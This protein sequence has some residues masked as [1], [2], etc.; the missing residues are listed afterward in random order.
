MNRINF[1]FDFAVDK[2]IKEEFLKYIFEERGDKIA[3][4]YYTILRKTINNAEK[5][6]NCLWAK[7]DSNMVD[8]ALMTVNTSSIATITT[9]IS[10]IRDYLLSTT[11]KDIECKTGYD[12]TF[13]LTIDDMRR[14]INNDTKTRRY[15]TPKEL[16]EIVLGDNGE[17]LSRA[18]CVLLYSG[19][20][21]EDILALTIDGINYETGDIWVNDK[22]VGKIDCKYFH[23]I[24]EAVSKNTFSHFNKVKRMYI[25]SEFNSY[26]EHEKLH[27]PKYFLRRF[28]DFQKENWKKPSDTIILSN[29]IN[30]LCYEIGY[31]IDPQS[32]QMSRVMYDLLQ[33]CNFNIPKNF[34]L[35][36]FKKI[37]G[38]KTTLTTAKDIC[39]LL[40]SKLEEDDMLNDLRENDRFITDLN[41]NEDIINEKGFLEGKIKLKEHRQKERNQNL[42]K[43]AKQNFKN[44]NGKIFCEICGF[45]FEKTY[46]ER[47]KDFIEVHHNI[48]IS[49][50]K[51]EEETKPSE[52]TLLCSCCHRMI[53]RKRPWLSVSRLKDLLYAKKITH[54]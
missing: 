46:G 11:P 41:N 33:Y 19:I 32:I 16:D 14:Y 10:I 21:K 1:N 23:I 40:L 7:F 53:H 8:N 28:L 2:I 13:K 29:R 34:Q 44:E 43:I 15:I 35:N 26:K 4:Q 6:N 24:K 25:N 52:L 31:K 42:I 50:L 22:T 30:D 45:D 20:S 12:Y 51:S 49:E 9:Y 18:L 54:Y 47:G 36:D 3:N 27:V 38:A 17:P 39:K 5:K 37:T 48:P